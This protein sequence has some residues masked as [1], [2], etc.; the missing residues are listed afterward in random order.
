LI[1]DNNSTPI[2][3]SLLSIGSIGTY[4]TD[5]NGLFEMEFSALYGSPNR[6][7]TVKAHKSGYAFPAKDTTFGST[8]T[9]VGEKLTGTSDGC[10]KKDLLK[11]QKKRAL[12]ANSLLL[13]K[14]ATFTE[15]FAR[16][17]LINNSKLTAR[18]TALSKKA[19]NYFSRYQKAELGLPTEVFTCKKSPTCK[20]NSYSSS[21]KN[22]LDFTE[23][24]SDLVA[25]IAVILSGKKVGLNKTATKFKKGANSQLKIIV[26]QTN[27]F[28][29]NKIA[30]K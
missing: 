3:P 29:R 10:T 15:L 16:L 8:E 17:D 28:P 12:A 6:S 27:L 18:A 13:K 24:F 9:I 4:F 23:K 25:Q 5:A 7:I 22:I 21:L 14:D 2:G 1:V 11:I 26:K 20:K 19:S 30:C